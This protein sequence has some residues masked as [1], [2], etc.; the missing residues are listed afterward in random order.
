MCSWKY[1]YIKYQHVLKLG[2]FVDHELTFFASIDIHII[3]NSYYRRPVTLVNIN[4]CS[5]CDLTSPTIL[6]SCLRV[7][8]VI[9]DWS[10]WSNTFCAFSPP[11]V[12]GAPGTSSGS[13]SHRLGQ[14]RFLMVGV[15]R[16]TWR[17]LHALHCA[18]RRD[19]TL[20][21]HTQRPASLTHI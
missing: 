16:S 8:E 18:D 21:T 3:L 15:N 20:W 10:L 4:V 13:I 14:P 17:K 7:S 12:W 2:F 1:I 11:D 5:G 9:L 6:L 19:A